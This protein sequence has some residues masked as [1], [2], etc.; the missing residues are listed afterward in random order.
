MRSILVIV[1]TFFSAVSY[2]SAQSGHEQM[3]RKDS[4]KEF[5]QGLSEEQKALLDS[6]KELRK[7]QKA[8][9]RATFSEE[10][11]T[12]VN[13]EEL[14]KR[15]RRRALVPTMSSKQREMANEHRE[16]MKAKNEEFK[17]TLSEEQL[18]AYRNLRKRK[19]KRSERNKEDH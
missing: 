5:Y 9:M 3:S 4:K 17:A 13:N 10:Q 6:Q 15:E 19:G 8:T 11:L 1:M 16:V 2:L 12:I 14:S 18:L 7:E